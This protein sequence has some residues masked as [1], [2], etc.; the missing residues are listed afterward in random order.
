MEGSEPSLT[1]VEKIGSRKGR[2]TNLIRLRKGIYDLVIY[3]ACGDIK[4]SYFRALS[5]QDIGLLLETVEEGEFC[6][7]PSNKQW[8]ELQWV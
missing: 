6:V 4:G 5:F 8:G 2:V 1:L 7:C 3:Q